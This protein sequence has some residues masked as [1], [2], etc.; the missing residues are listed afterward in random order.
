MPED[1][2]L[3]SWRFALE[4]DGQVAGTVISAAG[5]Y[6]TADVVTETIGDGPVADKH[7]GS[8]R[9]ADVEIACASDTAP[10]LT[11][12]LTETLNGK[13]ARRNGALLKLDQ[14]SKTVQRL[15]FT[16][17]LLAEVAFPGLDAA[18]T[19]PAR[20]AARLAPEYTRR[21]GGDGRTVSGGRAQQ[22]T[23]A[24]FRLAI[25]GLDCN[26]VT[27]IE[28]LAVRTT[29]TD[30]EDAEGRAVVKKPTGVEIPNL[31]VTL[32]ESA[33]QSF[34]AW[35]ED[36]VINGNSSEPNERSGTL[37]LLSSTMTVLFRV[38][39][40]GLGIYEVAPVPAAADTVPK[41]TASMY[42]QELEIAN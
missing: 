38:A 32:P 28:R 29:L 2:T 5:G 3:T 27:R 21:A 23:T 13:Y 7:L 18:S 6:G 1:S 10:Y 31:V 15:E 22:W 24:N 9:Y 35:H 19:A 4:L 41:V 42:C 34:F 14:Y 30:E 20:L 12:W 25:D 8:L 11:G 26:R 37:E 16:N 36:F 17:A 40:R 33:A 39:F